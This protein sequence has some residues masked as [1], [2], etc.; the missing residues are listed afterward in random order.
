[1]V[2]LKE[3]VAARP[4]RLQNGQMLRPGSFFMKSSSSAPVVISRKSPYEVREEGEGKFFLFEGEEKIDGEIFFPKPKPRVGAEPLTSKGTPISR[5]LISQR[6]CFILMPVRHC[7]YFSNGDQCKFCNFNS[8]QE[9]ARS[10]GLSRPVTEN[11]DECVEAYQIRSSEVKL[12]EG[13]FEMGGFTKGEREEAIHTSF[14]ERIAQAGPTKPFLLIHGEAMPRK[15]LQRLKDAGLDSLTIQIEAWDKQVFEASC[16]GKVKHTSYDGWVDS[17]SEAIDVFGVGSVACKTIGGIS[18]VAEGG[19]KTWQE[20]RDTHIEHIREMFKIGALPSIGCLRL[21][22]GSVWGTDASL[23]EKLPPTEYYLDLFTPHHEAMTETGY[24]DKL[25]KF[26]YCGFECAHAVYSGDIGIL[27]R[28]GNWGNWMSD[29]VPDKANWI[30]N[31]LRTI[32]STTT[33]PA[34]AQ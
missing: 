3:L 17:V 11:L 7:E 27:E 28:A 19:H 9:A 14:V 26:M 21:P 32:E 24:Y 1:E 20:A 33:A 4:S 31:W 8:G 29:V 2:D 22:V 13:R 12:Y 15:A 18:L 6:N 16:P 5:L 25:N 10:V 30:L 23:K 34:I